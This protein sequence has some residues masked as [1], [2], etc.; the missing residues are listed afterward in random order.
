MINYQSALC[1]RTFSFSENQGKISSIRKKEI[2]RLLSEQVKCN[3]FKIGKNLYLQQVGIAQGSKL[4]PNLC[5]LYYGHLENSVLLKFLHDCKINS[6]EDVLASKSLLMRFIDD[7]IFISFSKEDALNFIDRIRRGF[8]YYNCYMNESKYGFNFEV[9]NSE[10]CC[11][12]IYRGDDG[13]SF[14]PWSGLLINCE[15]LEIQ[16]D[17]TRYAYRFLIFVGE[18][19]FIYNN[20]DELH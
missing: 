2:L 20:G 17:Y 1:Q 19:N 10:N 13:F 5:S 8:V 16:A 4:S 7:F 3:I 12:R 18:L 6:D 9:P 14:I 11:N 15:T